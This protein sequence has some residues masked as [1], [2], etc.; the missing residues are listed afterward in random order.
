MATDKLLKSR[1]PRDRFSGQAIVLTAGDAF[2]DFDA[3]YLAT[4]PQAFR[5]V[6]EPVAGRVSSDVLSLVPDESMIR[7]VSCA[8][9]SLR[10]ILEGVLTRSSSFPPGGGL[11][12]ALGISESEIAA[13]P[14]G[15]ESDYKHF[16]LLYLDPMDP[17]DIND[18]Y[19]AYCTREF[20]CD[21]LIDRYLAG[22]E[23]RFSAAL[24]SYMDARGPLLAGTAET[25]A[26]LQAT[27]C[28]IKIIHDCLED[29]RF[30]GAIVRALV[31]VDV[32]E[33]DILSVPLARMGAEDVRDL[34]PGLYSI[35]ESNIFV[36][37]NHTGVLSRSISGEGSAARGDTARTFGN[38]AGRGRQAPY[39]VCMIGYNDSRPGL[40]APFNVRDRQILRADSQDSL[41]RHAKAFA[42][43][44]LTHSFVPVRTGQAAARGPQKKARVYHLPS[45]HLS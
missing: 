22:H 31:A 9:K 40:A 34:F 13:E 39:H 19:I 37:T 21:R 10:E 12:H 28:Q 32:P 14:F 23:A 26:A 20:I 27:G 45:S 41:V 33:N 2:V 17:D 18:S 3:P 29:E 25:V 30:S 6:F 15:D 4:V 5:A 7:I 44:A 11:L 1:F 16:K 42:S 35:R 43:G 38:V 36:V 24:D 8:G